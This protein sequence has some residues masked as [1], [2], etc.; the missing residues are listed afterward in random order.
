MAS[1]YNFNNSIIF[2][3]QLSKNPIVFEDN[4]SDVFMKKPLNLAN[5]HYYIYN[6][7]KI[8]TLYIPS[9]NE[10]IDLLQ[11]ETEQLENSIKRVEISKHLKALKTKDLRNV[12]ER[13]SEEDYYDRFMD[14][15]RLFTFEKQRKNSANTGKVIYD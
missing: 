7:D 9:I 15:R 5:Q 3:T 2:N 10:Q 1:L 13:I 8:S 6:Q 11:Q 12:I 4:K 14:R